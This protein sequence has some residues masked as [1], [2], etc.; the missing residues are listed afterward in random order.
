MDAGKLELETVNFDLYGCWMI[1]PQFSHPAQDKGLSC[2]V[3][4]IPAVLPGCKV[5]PDG[6]ARSSPI[7]WETP[8]KFTHVGEVTVHVSIIT[9]SNDEVLLRFAIR[10]TGIGIPADKI[11][12]LFNKFTQVD[13]S[14]TRQFGGTGWDWLSRS[15]WQN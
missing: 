3:E 12:L 4:S 1:L 7:W 6:C 10:D 9:Q 11:G 15:N 13:A 2:C 5:I 14:T 8:S